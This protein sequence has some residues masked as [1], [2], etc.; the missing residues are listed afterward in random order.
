M[1]AKTKWCTAWKEKQKI[2]H[3]HYEMI[4]WNLGQHWKLDCSLGHGFTMGAGRTLY[5]AV[6]SNWF[7]FLLLTSV[8]NLTTGVTWEKTF[9]RYVSSQ[10]P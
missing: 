10:R 4:E 5:I 2:Q 1:R 3:T 8:F 9:P 6:S 7:P